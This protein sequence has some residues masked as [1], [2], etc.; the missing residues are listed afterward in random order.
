MINQGKGC[1][2]VR[3][4]FFGLLYKFSAQSSLSSV[5]NFFNGYLL[6]DYILECYQNRS[7]RTC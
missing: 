2:F 4:D 3:K 6:F 1:K 5:V 7:L